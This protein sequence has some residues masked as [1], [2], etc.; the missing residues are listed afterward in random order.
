CPKWIRGVLQVM[1]VNLSTPKKYAGARVLAGKIPHRRFRPVPRS[2]WLEYLHRGCALPP[3][4]R[5]E[6]SPHKYR[7]RQRSRGAVRF[8]YELQLPSKILALN[9]PSRPLASARE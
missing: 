1:R 2:R 8:L 7:A 4:R 3:P 5:S 6:Q 9:D